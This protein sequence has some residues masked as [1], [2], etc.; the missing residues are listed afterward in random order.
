[1]A[2][3]SNNNRHVKRERHTHKPIDRFDATKR[4]NGLVAFFDILGYA[5]FV[6]N[7]KI[8]YVVHVI[9][10]AL[11]AVPQ[12]LAK[13]GYW[14]GFPPPRRVVFADSIL[15]Y[16][17]FPAKSSSDKLAS[18]F[19][20]PFIEY[21]SHFM[22]IL[23]RGGLPVRGGID[24]GDFYVQGT[25][26]AGRPII[27]AH[28]LSKIPMAGC[29][30]SQTV[31]ELI[32]RANGPYVSEGLIQSGQGVLEFN[33]IDSEGP[34]KKLNLLEFFP[35]AAFELNYENVLTKF[36]RHKKVMDKEEID[37]KTKNK[38]DNTLKFLE[39]CRE[40]ERLRESKFNKFIDSETPRPSKQTQQN[41]RA[42]S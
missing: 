10:H 16:S 21:C 28:S 7:N 40:E 18:D 3:L 1:M 27:E 22:S 2:E 34:P 4:M 17:P 30:L 37:A 24:S 41:T 39:C 26:F 20:P 38:V 31:H 23:F 13:N 19:V 14:V 36:V 11:R 33:A 29:V 6:K 15:I 25:I 42:A 9:N 5:Q 32:T 35:F 8:E 12:K